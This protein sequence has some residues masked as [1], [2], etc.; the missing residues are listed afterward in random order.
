MQRLASDDGG[1]E[2]PNRIHGMTSMPLSTP[3]SSLLNFDPLHL[4]CRSSSVDDSSTD[5]RTFPPAL[6]GE[7][8]CENQKFP[9]GSSTTRVLFLVDR[10]V[11]KVFP[12]QLQGHGQVT[13]AVIHVSWRCHAQLLVPALRRDQ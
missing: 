13:S 8:I 5:L 12:S 4:A 7:G 9:V 2:V 11:S 1:A 10:P 6:S 3:S